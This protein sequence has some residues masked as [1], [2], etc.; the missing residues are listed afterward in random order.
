[1]SAEDAGLLA[2]EEPN[3][4]VPSISA[5]DQ[6]SGC[7]RVIGTHRAGSVMASARRIDELGGEPL[8]RRHCP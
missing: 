4:P 3:L 2:S 6:I 8:A 1:M 5:K 7:D